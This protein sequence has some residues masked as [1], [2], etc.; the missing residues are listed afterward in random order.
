VKNIQDSKYSKA[1][2]DVQT[3]KNALIKEVNAYV[4]KLS[5]DLNNKIKSIHDSIDTE[6]KKVEKSRT[7]LEEQTNMAKDINL[8]PIG[9]TFCRTL[10]VSSPIH[11]ELSLHTHTNWTYFISVS[12]SLVTFSLILVS[13]ITAPSSACND[14]ILDLVISPGTNLTILPCFRLTCGMTLSMDFPNLSTVVLY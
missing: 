8:F 2:E 3:Q 11:N 1:M 9:F 5:Y 14:P 4:H 13:S 6:K 12:N 10:D 7:I